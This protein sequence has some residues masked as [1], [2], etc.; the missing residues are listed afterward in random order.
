MLD[1]WHFWGGGS[2]MGIAHMCKRS[3]PYITTPCPLSCLLKKLLFLFMDLWGICN[4]EFLDSDMIFL[5]KYH[6]VPA[7]PKFLTYYPIGLSFKRSLGTVCLKFAVLSIPL[8]L[9]YHLL[10]FATTCAE[11]PLESAFMEKSSCIWC[12]LVFSLWFG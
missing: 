7:L 3:G 11:L 2:A 9:L 5:A 6:Q 10:S 1:Q 8:V 12:L 4:P